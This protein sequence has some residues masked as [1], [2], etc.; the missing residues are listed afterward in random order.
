MNKK[1]LTQKI[2]AKLRILEKEGFLPVESIEEVKEY[3][4]L[5]WVQLNKGKLIVTQDVRAKLN[6]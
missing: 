6:N 4:K 2:K 3:I 1:R 5:G